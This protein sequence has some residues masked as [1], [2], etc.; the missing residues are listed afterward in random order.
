MVR[1]AIRWAG[2]YV[3]E[4]GPLFLEADTYRYHGHSMSDPGI[5]YRTK[6]EIQAI[7][8]GRDPVEIAKR[9]L[10]EFKWATEEELKEKEKE[11][12]KKLDDEYEQIKNDPFPVK[13]D[14]YTHIGTTPQHYIRDIEYKTS[15]HIDPKHLQ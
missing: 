9:M 4:H 12:K 5:T 10:I 1:E 8:D 2:A 6:E 14:L 7:R 13:E 3:K 11:I 15:K